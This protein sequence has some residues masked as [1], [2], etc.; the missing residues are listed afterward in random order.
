MIA[1]CTWYEDRMATNKPVRMNHLRVLTAIKDGVHKEKVEKIRAAKDRQEAQLIKETLPATVFSSVCGDARTV[2]LIKSYSGF[3]S[4]DFDHIDGMYSL[5]YTEGNV[6][7]LPA[8]TEVE[9][10]EVVE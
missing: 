7:H 6:V 3:M 4:L 1:D 5:C 9:I 8:W 10:V 2:E